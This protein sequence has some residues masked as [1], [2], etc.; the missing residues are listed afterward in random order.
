VT[1]CPSPQF[2]IDESNTIPNPSTRIVYGFSSS[3][4]HSLSQP[5]SKLGQEPTALPQPQQTSQVQNE[6][7]MFMLGDST[8][9]AKLPGKLKNQ[10]F[11][12][13]VQSR[14]IE[15]P[16]TEDEDVIETDDAW[17][18]TDG[19]AWEDCDPKSGPANLT[20]SR[21]KS[22]DHLTSRRSVLTMQLQNPSSASPISS[23]NGNENGLTLT[24]CGLQ[25]GQ[26]IPICPSTGTSLPSPGTSLQSPTTPP[27]SPTTPPPGPT[28]TPANSPYTIRQNM[29]TGE[30]A[31]SSRLAVLQ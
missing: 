1:P 29:L 20:F 3:R 23:P 17:S 7:D 5:K 16:D 2:C 4:H 26:P 28:P 15:W 6:G 21:V 27:A 14:R 11:K 22:Q 12:E 19:D 25:S 8:S 13:I 30:V 18:D 10:S 9:K 24:M 31:E